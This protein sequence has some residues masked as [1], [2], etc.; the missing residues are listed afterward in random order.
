MNNKPFVETKYY[1]PVLI[2][3][4]LFALFLLLVNSHRHLT[5]LEDRVAQETDWQQ[6]LI[7]DQK[8]MKME[9]AMLKSRQRIEAIAKY[10][11]QMDYPEKK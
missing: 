1:A 4:L 5:L 10:R 7:E 6:Q 2:I 11:L 9:I 3:L 8:K